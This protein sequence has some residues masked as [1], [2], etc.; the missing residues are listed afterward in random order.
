MVLLKEI[1]KALEPYP[2]LH[3]SLPFLDAERFIRFAVRVKR[4]I[5]LNQPMTAAGPPLRL[6]IYIHE[7]LRDVLTFQDLDTFQ[8]WSAFQHIIWRSKLTAD[9]SLSEAALFDRIG[10][11]KSRA[12]EQIGE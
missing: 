1:I 10:S 6:P 2:D 9:L 3:D 5:R 12:N 8:C 7:F 11:R 4:E